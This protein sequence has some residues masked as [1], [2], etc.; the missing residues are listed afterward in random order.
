MPATKRRIDPV[1]SFYEFTVEG[2]GEFP[3]DMLRRDQ[4]WPR[5]ESHDVTAL[6]PHHRSSVL[7]ETRQVQLVG[8][9]EPTEGRWA[10]FGWRVV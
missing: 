6:A 4:C 5:R 1:K 9:C 10:S 3:F 2:K 7:R 8:L